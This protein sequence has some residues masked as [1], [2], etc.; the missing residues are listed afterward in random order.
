MSEILEVGSHFFL[1]GGGGVG[2]FVVV[3]VVVVVVVLFCFFNQ[4]CKPFKELYS[5][6]TLVNEALWPNFQFLPTATMV[7]RNL[8]AAIVL[9][10]ATPCWWA[11][12][13]AI[14]TTPFGL[15]QA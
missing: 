2:F 7:R 14:C 12:V 5:K 13:L 3:V 1:G 8:A 4:F 9:R 15:G 10:A 6:S 11:G